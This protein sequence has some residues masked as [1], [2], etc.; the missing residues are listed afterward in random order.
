MEILF[1]I[2]PTGLHAR[3]VGTSS[4]EDYKEIEQL[5][6]KIEHHAATIREVVIDISGMEF[7]DSSGLGLLLL[8]KEHCDR[9]RV[10]IQLQN[11]QGQVRRIIE[12]SRLNE[13]FGL[14]YQ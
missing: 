7:M 6:L 14:P 11:P 4:F 8:L 1:S 13:L 5:C 10:C 9:C 3:F 12:A 2:S